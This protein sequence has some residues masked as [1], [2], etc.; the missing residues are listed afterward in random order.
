MILSEIPLKC[1]CNQYC[2]YVAFEQLIWLLFWLIDFYSLDALNKLEHT[3]DFQSFKKSGTLQEL[4][5]IILWTKQVHWNYGPWA[6]QG[7]WSIFNQPSAISK[8]VKL[9]MAHI[10]SQGLCLNEE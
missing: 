6:N 8:K 7:P 5:N 1:W 10:K 3:S 4:W 2:V 9:N